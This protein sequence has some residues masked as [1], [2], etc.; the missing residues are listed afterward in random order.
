[1]HFLPSTIRNNI[2][3][4]QFPET[5]PHLQLLNA[6]NF[7][8]DL[9]CLKYKS[10]ECLSK[11]LS[12][13]DF[14]AITLLFPSNS[15]ENLYKF[16]QSIN[17]RDVGPNYVSNQLQQ[18]RLPPYV[19]EDALTYVKLKHQHKS[20]KL[21]QCLKRLI[22]KVIPEAKSFVSILDL[23]YQLYSDLQDNNVPNILLAILRVIFEIE[24]FTR[25]G[26]KE[27]IKNTSILEYFRNPKPLSTKKK[28]QFGW[29]CLSLL[30]G[31]MDK[32]TLKH[33]FNLVGEN[34]SPTDSLK[35][36][37]SLTK[38]KFKSI[39]SLYD[40]PNEETIFRVITSMNNCKLYWEDL[41]K[42]FCDDLT[43]TQIINIL[44]SCTG[45]KQLYHIRTLA[46]KTN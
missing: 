34:Y 29:D 7:V 45:S 6:K 20:H 26:K 23:V 21:F 8:S 3:K 9:K 39:N 42:L 30:V 37:R 46:E 5:L 14:E 13:N 19:K 33:I 18:C 38:K 22:I 15:S 11:L 2:S 25:R 43:A 24:N 12:G 16:L 17:L 4:V 28:I 10:I 32:E 44:Y 36:I 40:N 27:E 1:L 41:G 35:C 31:E